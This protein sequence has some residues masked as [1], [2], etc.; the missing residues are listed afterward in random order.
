MTPPREPLSYK[1]LPDG[2]W[3]VIYDDGTRS[4]IW[5]VAGSGQIAKQGLVEFIQHA[6][7]SQDAVVTPQ[8]SGLA[9]GPTGAPSSKD[10]QREDLSVDLSEFQQALIHAMKTGKVK[11]TM[12]A[13]GKAQVDFA[14]F[15]KW[16]AEMG[17]N[18]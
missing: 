16:V 15:Q 11:Y 4:I 12:L 5:G 6:D 1:R 10:F 8:P 18:G 9:A 2:S 3:E 13:E 14:S 7:G 17:L